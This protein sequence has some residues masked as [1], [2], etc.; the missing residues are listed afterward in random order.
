MAASATRALPACN[1]GPGRRDD[2]KQTLQGGCSGA[3]G[4][5]PGGAEPGAEPRAEPTAEA[6]AGAT[7]G[8]PPFISWTSAS[9]AS[10][11]KDDQ[12]ACHTPPCVGGGG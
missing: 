11:L 2:A 8:S 7:A 6:E 10:G 4:P 9:A 3:P 5:L 12:R 1:L